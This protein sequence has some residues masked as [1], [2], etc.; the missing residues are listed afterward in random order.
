MATHLLNSIKIL[1]FHTRDM[2]ANFVEFLYMYRAQKR[3]SFCRTNINIDTIG[4]SRALLLRPKKEQ[5]QY[6]NM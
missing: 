5:F 2:C 4:L 1:K 6:V 3:T